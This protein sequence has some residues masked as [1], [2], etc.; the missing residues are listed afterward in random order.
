MTGGELFF[1]EFLKLLHLLDVV[2]QLNLLSGCQ[3]RM[4]PML[5]R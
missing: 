3:Q 2:R 1:R 4:R 5:L